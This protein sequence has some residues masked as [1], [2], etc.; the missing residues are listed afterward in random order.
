M[1]IVVVFVVTLSSLQWPGT[2]TGA[3]TL[4]VSPSGSS[5][6][7]ARGQRRCSRPVVRNVVGIGVAGFVRGLV[8][9]GV[10]LVAAVT[11]AAI[12]AVVVSDRYQW[13]HYLLQ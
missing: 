7:Q 3:L 10:D 9:A 13:G 1:V 5:L 12:V 11:V 6:P 2:P 4:P 8:A